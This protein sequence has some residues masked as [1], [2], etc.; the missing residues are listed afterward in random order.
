MSN[1][2]IKM[3]SYDFWCL[4]SEHER[5]AVKSGDVRSIM[6]CVKIRIDNVTTAVSN[7]D[8]ENMLAYEHQ[9]ENMNVAYRLLESAKLANQVAYKNLTNK[10]KAV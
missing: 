6:V 2:D 9:E 1:K 10:K 7:S 8:R 5:L 3:S 4:R